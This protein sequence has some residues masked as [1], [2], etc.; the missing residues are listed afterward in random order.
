MIT[1]FNN[2]IDC[3]GR[4]FHVQTED[5]GLENPVVESLVYSGGEIVTARKTPY[6][7]LVVAGEVDDAEIL[8]RME[9]QHREL[10]R[11]IRN[12]KYSNSENKPFGHGIVTNRPFD[13]VVVTFLRDNAE[14]LLRD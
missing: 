3:E 11:D 13:E 7:D 4:I 8:R 5:R 1:G 12:G 9:T 6:T 2:D 14:S 10:I